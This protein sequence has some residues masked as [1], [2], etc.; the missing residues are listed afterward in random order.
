M[1][2]PGY[3]YLESALKTANKEILSF[4][5]CGK[6]Y[7]YRELNVVVKKLYP[8]NGK[9]QKQLQREFEVGLLINQYQS[10]YLVKTLGFFI[11]EAK[12]LVYLVTEY[13]PGRCLADYSKATNIFIQLLYTIRHLQ[14]QMEFTHYDLH[15][16]NVIVNVLP[17]DTKKTYQFDG[18][19]W[20]INSLY[21]IKIIDFARTHVTGVKPMYYQS[22]FRDSACCPGIYDPIFDYGTFLRCFAKA[23]KLYQRENGFKI[24]NQPIVELLDQNKM[25]SSNKR[26]FFLGYPV[27]GDIPHL[28][29]FG[30]TCGWLSTEPGN[31][32]IEEVLREFCTIVMLQN[33]PDDT[34]PD[35]IH[36]L[37][38]YIN[39]HEST[40]DQEL[41]DSYQKKLGAACVHDKLLQIVGRQHNQKQMFE[42][43]CQI[44]KDIK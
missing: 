6:V 5:P 29:C 17:E 44:V 39:D 12:T 7:L 4:L 8:G 40:I 20:T 28:E 42:A 41:I 31:Q 26:D 30:D 22:G 25:Y 1:W 10:P 21:D 15:F 27:T 35:D 9:I 11:E 37:V 13:V 43:C 33:H 18:M 36:S 3:D 14:A 32:S 24:T 34:I 16:Y 38:S 23:K 19:I 2:A